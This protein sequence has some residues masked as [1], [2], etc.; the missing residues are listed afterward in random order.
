MKKKEVKDIQDRLDHL[1]NTTAKVKNTLDKMSLHFVIPLVSFYF[2]VGLLLILLNETVTHVAAWALAAGLILA[3]GWLL[4]RYLRADIRKRLAGADMA[5]GLVLLLAGILLIASPT[6]MRDVFPKIWGL[7]L[8]FGGFLK[9][10]Y[11]F[12]EWSVHVR[13]W[14]I[15][16]IFATVSL[17][18]GILALLNK[19]IFGSSQH[20][21][22]GIFMIGEAA[23]DLVT[24]FLLNN[25]MKKQNGLKEMQATAP[26]AAAE[27]KTLPEGT[28]A[29]SEENVS[30]E[31]V[32]A[33]PRETTEQEE[34]PNADTEIPEKVPEKEE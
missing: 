19:S 10:Q 14:W 8:I 17:T 13:R 20:L 6:D 23:L 30:A 18:I 4:I 33:E 3:G 27:P 16:L 26:E 9:I 28:E 5:M 21:V 7:S 24:Y 29:T 2:I 12:D 25:G 1:E 31:T 11:A 15:M 34:T 32:P 22:V